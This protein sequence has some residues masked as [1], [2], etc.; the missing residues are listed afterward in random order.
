MACRQILSLLTR[1]YIL[2]S[3]LWHWIDV[4]ACQ[5][6]YSLAGLYDNTVP[7]S[8]ISPSQGLRIWLQESGEGE[9]KLPPCT[10]PGKRP[11]IYWMDAPSFE[12]K[13]QENFPH[14]FGSPVEI[15]IKGQI[16]LFRH[17]NEEDFF[18]CS[19]ATDPS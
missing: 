16:V 6:M 4:L 19:L 15:G 5:P 18:I 9:S 8:T 17:I 1:G 12:L 13:N 10:E 2:Y 3:R 14:L 11:C 7:E